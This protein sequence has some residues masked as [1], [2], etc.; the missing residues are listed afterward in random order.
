MKIKKVKIQAFKSY[1]KEEDS[2]FD[3]TW[4]ENKDEVANIISIYAPNGF[5]KTSFYDAVDYCYTHNITR[6]IRDE[7]VK[8]QNSKN[9]N[10]QPYII[11]NTSVKNSKIKLDTKVTIITDDHNEI[12]SPIVKYNQRG[13]DYKFDD[14]K[15]PDDRKYFRDL[16]LS[17]DAIDA[18]L[19]ETDPV[20][21]FNKFAT[22]QINT[23]SQLNDSRKVIQHVLNE[24]DAKIK[25]NNSQEKSLSEELS[26]YD[27]DKDIIEQLNNSISACNSL[28]F[29][30]ESAI[31]LSS[32]KKIIL[33]SFELTGK[34][35]VTLE[36]VLKSQKTLEYFIKNSSSIKNM[37]VQLNQI[38]N[39]TTEIDKT[40]ANKKSLSIIDKSLVNLN[41]IIKK[42]NND[43]NEINN[44][45]LFTPIFYNQHNNKNELIIK[46]Q[47]LDISSK[48]LYSKKEKMNQEINELIDTSTQKKNKRNELITQ[49]QISP[50]KFKDLDTYEK[51]LVKSERNINS[52]TKELISI[53]LKKKSH[54]LNIKSLKSIDIKTFIEQD[55]FEYK[56]SE[57]N[58]FHKIFYSNI[59]EIDKLSNKIR[60]SEDQ[61]KKLEEYDKDIIKL[62]SLGRELIT[63]DS[64]PQCPLC[65]H[66]YDDF[67]ALKNAIESNKS[68]TNA[69][70]ENLKS[71]ND[72]KDRKISLEKLNEKLAN[73]HRDII[74]NYI[75][76]EEEFHKKNNALSLSLE[77]TIQREKNSLAA[78]SNK[79]NIL[80]LETLSLSQNDYLDFI[81]SEIK[82]IDID[83]SNLEKR[84]KEIL[85]DIN[86]NNKEIDDKKIKA[87]LINKQIE[88]I[89][90]TKEYSDIFYFT[91]NNALDISKGKEYLSS[92]LD[93]IHKKTADKLSD[94]KSSISLELERKEKLTSEMSTKFSKMEKE[95][96][97]ILKCELQTKTKAI[98][99]ELSIYSEE[100]D[101]VELKESD[102]PDV[103]LIAQEKLK[104]SINKKSESDIKISNLMTLTQLAEKANSLSDGLKIT[105]ELESLNNM[106]Q[107]LLAM[108]DMFSDDI[109]KIDDEIKSNINEFF[110]VDL[111][112][113]I[114]NTIDPHP[115]F[116]HINFNYVPNKKPELHI[117]VSDKKDTTKIS[118]ALHFSSAQINVLSLSIFLAKALNTRNNDGDIVD[119]IFIDDPIQS[120][121]AINI[122]SVIDLLRNISVRFNKQLIIS[123]HDENFHELLKKKIPCNLFRSKFLRLE[124]FGKVSTDL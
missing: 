49:K 39:E 54:E 72:L 51:E 35:Q 4:N 55:L 109:N 84:R 34:E 64:S 18:F 98:I 117:T 116:K 58:Q 68:I 79:I 103:I 2:T 82:Q 9:A 94:A 5:G 90:L 81:S 19:R 42:Y 91:E 11:R 53:E 47:Q 6:Y 120:M 46:K 30:I 22:K 17:Q 108:K 102:L 31:G 89:E 45:K 41:S 87:T 52:A 38:Q 25:N 88:D 33:T 8:K 50:Q 119:C 114:Y 93:T 77:Q 122:L 110:Y 123:T 57:L 73:Q 12:C 14:T 36:K 16:M 56:V 124:S 62:L 59:K 83:I 44:Y 1:L 48:T 7:N 99:N 107:N 105:Q 111:I 21:R 69:F 26:K 74:N 66:V 95:K 78:L 3:F 43:I 86:K 76:L 60:L 13:N 28:G 32:F 20:E 15:T 10:H 113:E 101:G 92:Q 100:L 67:L 112:N 97:D 104:D 106:T 23:L 80:R 121:D 27:L 71:I 65:N 40:A 37:I 118:P 24:V 61:L 70:N 75:R 96:L 29:E 115:D 63:Y 85:L